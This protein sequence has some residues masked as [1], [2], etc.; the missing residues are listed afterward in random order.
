MPAVRG[1]MAAARRWEEFSLSA[2]QGLLGRTTRVGA[3]G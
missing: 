3:A 2:G 1:G